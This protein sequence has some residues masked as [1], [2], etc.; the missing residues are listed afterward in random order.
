VPPTSWISGS[1]EA[2]T[3]ERTTAMTD[4]TD[5]Y[6]AARARSAASHPIRVIV[7]GEPQR[8]DDGVAFV[9]VR[10]AMRG[11]EPAAAARVEVRET[12]QLDPA[13]LV[14]LAPDGAAIVI[15]AVVGLPPG[16]IV[17]IPLEDL[18]AEGPV[19]ARS[20]HVLPVDQLVG[21]AAALRGSPPPGVLV[22]IG[23]ER[24][25]FGIGLS[26][27]VDEAVQSFA[28]RIRSEITRAASPG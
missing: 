7:L 28:D 23:G 24:F 17:V 20:T 18:V 9:A 12:G 14:E 16:E 11:L 4:T 26:P 22:G 2:D 1:N 8:G 25:A 27:A 21:L 15:D 13:D 5:A 6:A 19:Q 10:E 3:D